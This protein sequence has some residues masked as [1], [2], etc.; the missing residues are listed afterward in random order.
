MRQKKGVK[1]CLML[2]Y[3][4]CTSETMLSTLVFADEAAAALHQAGAISVIRSVPDLVDDQDITR[5]KSALVKR[6][7][8]L[9]HD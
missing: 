8:D 7:E 2:K 3:G 9:R 1:M 4:Q 5:Y 6:F